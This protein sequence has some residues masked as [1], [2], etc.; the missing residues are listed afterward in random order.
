M[1]RHQVSLEVCPC[2]ELLVMWELPLIH[3]RN[4]SLASLSTLGHLHPRPSHLC[5]IPERCFWEELFPY[6]AFPAP[7]ECTHQPVPCSS[8]DPQGWAFLVSCLLVSSPRV[9]EV[10]TW[11]SSNPSP[12]S[13]LGRYMKILGRVPSSLPARTLIDTGLDMGIKERLQLS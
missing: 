7:C 11:I 6:R 10:Y 2:A 4:S 9:G 8:Q 5:S 13:C 3:R 1:P 12:H